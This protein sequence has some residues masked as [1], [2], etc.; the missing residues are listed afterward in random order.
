MERNTKETQ[1]KVELTLDAKGL[2][3]NVHTGVGMDVFFHR[4][5]SLGFLDHM[6]NA[7]C[8]FAHFDVTLQ[9]TGDLHIDDHHSYVVYKVIH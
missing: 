5:E 6:I 7:M 2:N 1:I 4:I 8:K 9:C 3:I